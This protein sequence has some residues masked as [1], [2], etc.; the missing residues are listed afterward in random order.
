MTEGLRA[1]AGNSL[2]NSLLKFT[3]TPG[4]GA[5]TGAISTSILQSSSA[6]VV[7]TVGFVTAGL[8]TFPQALGIILGANIG[9]T[10]TG[11]LV[12]LLGFKLQ[13]G[14]IVLPLIFLGATLRLFSKGRLAHYGLSLA[15][16][17]LIFV[18]I[19]FMQEGMSELPNVI[20]PEN[21]PTDTLLGSLKLVLLGIIATL[22]TQ[23][24][25]AGIAATLTAVF[26]GA[27]NF[28]QAAA[29]IIGM[30]IGTTVTAL[31]ACL[32]GSTASRRTGFSHVIYNIFTAIGALLLIAPYSKLWETIAPGQLNLNAEIALVA[33]H[34]LFNILGVIIILPFSNRFAQLMKNLVPEKTPGYT[35][36]LD[37]TLLAEPVIALTVIQSI[38]EKEFVAI[39]RHTNALLS[40]NK[41]RTLEN[42]DELQHALDETQVFVDQIHIKPSADPE[43]NKLLAAIHT[44]DHLQ[45]LHERCYEESDRA[46]SALK[47]DSLKKYCRLIITTNESILQAIELN[48]WKN[49]SDNA[50]NTTTLINQIIES[51]RNA[52][53]YEVANGSINVPDATEALEATRW[54]SRV[55]HHI[56]RITSHIE[57]VR[58]LNNKLKGMIS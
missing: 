51:H 52:I 11:W 16:F 45:R 49:A 18:G 8:M 41:K 36:G 50:N 53:F 40:N 42:L 47:N 17:G 44:L 37:K 30:D 58:M 6:T 21:F 19:T 26:A 29:L 32:G 43:S 13:L 1:L 2:R 15:G 14:S 28:P 35:Q 9:T 46:A 38:I 27:I 25:S 12:V 39:L 7:A 48:Q 56:F 24:S 34:T 57:E 10:I 4:S 31:I 33:F 22:I 20:T 54:L 3:K 5:I 23:S 55:S